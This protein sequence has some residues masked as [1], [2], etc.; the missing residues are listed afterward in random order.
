MAATIM[1]SAR[2]RPSLSLSAEYM[3]SNSAFAHYLN[4]VVFGRMCHEM[5]CVKAVIFVRLLN[6]IQPTHVTHPHRAVRGREI[7]IVRVANA[8]ILSLL[9]GRR[10]VQGFSRNHEFVLHDT[11]GTCSWI[12]QLFSTIEQ[13]GFAQFHRAILE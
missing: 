10:K 8:Q 11:A 5:M 9:I 13:S 4:N 1:S 12:V 6:A 7:L 3:Y 2:T